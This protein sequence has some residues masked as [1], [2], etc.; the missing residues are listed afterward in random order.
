MDKAVLLVDNNIEA[1]LCP[2]D[3][4]TRTILNNVLQVKGFIPVYTSLYR[5]EQ[6][7]SQFPGLI[8]TNVVA[9]AEQLNA[10]GIIVVG[11]FME[12]Y[13]EIYLDAKTRTVKIICPQDVSGCNATGLANLLGLIDK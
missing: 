8:V 1:L 2:S 3:L 10:D 4:D 6:Q 9:S 11:W 7:V 12:R 13:A 5:S